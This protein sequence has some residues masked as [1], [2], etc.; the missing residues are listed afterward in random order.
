MTRT[1][2]RPGLDPITEP[3]SRL[4]H[5]IDQLSSRPAVAWTLLGA[6]LVWVLLSVALGFP[7]RLESIFQ[8]VVAAVTVALVFVIQHTQAREQLVTQRK[9]D[10]LLRAIPR[11]NNALI[12]LEEASDTE[13]AD[14]HAGHRDVRA[15]AVRA[16]VG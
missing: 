6:D 7:A 16:Q 13:L 4:L 12:G 11:A 1:R 3:G 2:R 15:E 9:L 8:T 14:V 10:E 5:V